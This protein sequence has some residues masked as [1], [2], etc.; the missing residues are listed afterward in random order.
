[1][2]KNKFAKY[3]LIFTA[4]EYQRQTT[5]SSAEVFSE[6][7]MNQLYKT[8]LFSAYISPVTLR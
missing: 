4:E 3:P 1:M 7:V 8:L 6:L 2:F 5:Q